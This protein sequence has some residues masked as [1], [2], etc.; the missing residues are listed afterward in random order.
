MNKKN[1][2]KRPIEERIFDVPGQVL[3]EQTTMVVS[4]EVPAEKAV[5]FI[6]KDQLA[7]VLRHEIMEKTGVS[8]NDDGVTVKVSAEIDWG[9][10]QFEGITIE[11]IRAK[12]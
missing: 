1:T 8:I 7:D 4:K 11:V 3:H 5:W 6:D 2:N 9:G 12:G 10:E